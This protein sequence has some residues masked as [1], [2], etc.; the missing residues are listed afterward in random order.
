MVSKGHKSM[1]N[2]FSITLF[3]YVRFMWI[4]FFPLWK[5]S[6]SWKWQQ[7]LSKLNL[8]IY[9]IMIR[10][11]YGTLMIPFDK[12]QMSVAWLWILLE[13][14]FPRLYFLSM[15]DT[16]FIVHPLFNVGILFAVPRVHPEPV[17]AAVWGA[18]GGQAATQPLHTEES[19]TLHREGRP[20]FRQGRL[21]I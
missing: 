13:K 6:L 2:I 7:P 3:S 18:G 5:L 19:A 14:M 8:C 9:E 12:E 15:Q 11:T 4:N 21:S 16:S 20:S 10:S 1:H 17:R